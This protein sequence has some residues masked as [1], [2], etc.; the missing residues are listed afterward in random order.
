VN[1]LSLTQIPAACVLLAGRVKHSE[2]LEI[3][4]WLN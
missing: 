4:G 1:S 2:R 3:R